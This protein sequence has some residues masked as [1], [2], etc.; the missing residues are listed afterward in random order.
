MVGKIKIG[1]FT[2]ISVF[3]HR[4]EKKN[5]MRSDFRGW[6]L[7]IWFERSKIVGKIDFS[8]PKKWSSRLVNSYMIGMNLLI[9]KFWITWD[10]GGMHIKEKNG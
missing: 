8:N 3:K 5:H 4:F 6:S 1:D 2:L 7:G 9:C 10:F